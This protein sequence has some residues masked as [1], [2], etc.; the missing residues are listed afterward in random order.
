MVPSNIRPKQ[1]HAK[2][3]EEKVRPQ[4]GESAL[5]FYHTQWQ[6]EVHAFGVAAQRKVH[7]PVAIGRQIQFRSLEQLVFGVLVGCTDRSRSTSFSGS[8]PRT[9]INRRV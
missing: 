4:I 5:A 3:R 8:R 9:K 2:R 6:R 1:D 7:G